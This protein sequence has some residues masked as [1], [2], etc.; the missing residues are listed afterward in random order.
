LK[1]Q[2]SSL[3]DWSSIISG[4]SEGASSAMQGAQKAALTKK[5][6]KEAKKRTLANLLSKAL[7]R[8]LGTFKAGQEYSDE[9]NEAQTQ[10]LQNTARGF[11]SALQGSTNRRFK[12]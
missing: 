12:G 7:K 2:S 10:A 5:E 9:M 6:A 1:K 8:R 11:V 4:A 3:K